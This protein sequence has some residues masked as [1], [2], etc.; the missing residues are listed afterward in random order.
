[1]VGIFY[2]LGGV[3]NLLLGKYIVVSF[4]WFKDV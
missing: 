3:G 4:S 1:M 2:I